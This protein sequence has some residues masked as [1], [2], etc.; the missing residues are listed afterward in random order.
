MLIDGVEGGRGGRGGER[1]EEERGRE[2]GGEGQE[3]ERRGGEEER[4]RG[5][6]GREEKRGERGDFQN[7][8]RCKI[9]WR[10]NI[11]QSYK[12]RKQNHIA[13]HVHPTVL[14]IQCKKRSNS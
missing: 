5:G 8:T 2:R 11:S 10:Q 13:Q 9:M 14:V 3:G 4:G 1:G 7:I 12:I 6:E